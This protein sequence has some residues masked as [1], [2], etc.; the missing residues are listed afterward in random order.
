[1]VLEAIFL[2]IFAMG[3]DL[4]VVSISVVKLFPLLLDHPSVDL[5]QSHSAHQ[6]AGTIMLFKSFFESVYI[7]LKLADISPEETDD[8]R[9]LA[10][11]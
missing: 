4:V 2:W 3:S 7:W 6:L 8:R 10:K 9:E 5:I 1:M 11:T